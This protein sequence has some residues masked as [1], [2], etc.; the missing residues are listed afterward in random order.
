MVADS[1][2]DSAQAIVAPDTAADSQEDFAQATSALG[3]AAAALEAVDQVGS[4]VS[5]DQAEAMAA[6]PQ[7]VAAV[8]RPLAALAGHIASHNILV[9]RSAPAVE[10][11][12][13]LRFPRCSFTTSDLQCNYIILRIRT[14][15][16]TILSCP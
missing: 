14:L 16:V 8:Y 10:A 2:E 5:V 9:A 4:V 11:V 6:A 12:V 13:V 3:R 15:F 7:P 1:R